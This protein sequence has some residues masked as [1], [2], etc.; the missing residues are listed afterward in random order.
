VKREEKTPDNGSTPNDNRAGGTAP[1]SI[2]VGFRNGRR[3]R[4]GKGPD[5]KT[6]GK[7]ARRVHWRLT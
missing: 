7:K 6:V 2:M 4:A 5:K 3:T 1:P